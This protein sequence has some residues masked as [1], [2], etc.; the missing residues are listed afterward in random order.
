MEPY[1]KF[2]ANV[3]VSDGSFQKDNWWFVKIKDEDRIFES[4]FAFYG[5]MYGS[6]TA[7]YGAYQVKIPYNSS[8]IF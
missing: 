7:Y 2:R 3:Y 5:G 4:L 8:A 1:Q 6:T